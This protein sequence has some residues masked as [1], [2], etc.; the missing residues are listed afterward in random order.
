MYR[1]L[2]KLAHMQY[3]LVVLGLAHY[4]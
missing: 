1:K 3:K 4:F 2:S